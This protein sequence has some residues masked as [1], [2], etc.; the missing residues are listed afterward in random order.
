M[1]HQ[2]QFLLLIELLCS[3]RVYATLVKERESEVVCVKMENCN[4][5][6]PLERLNASDGYEDELVSLTV[7]R[8]F[9]F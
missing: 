4:C 9:F 6:K 3:F 1:D 5:T 8:D 7:L 2:N